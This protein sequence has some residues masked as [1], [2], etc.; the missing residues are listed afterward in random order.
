MCR[1][2]AAD[3]NICFDLPHKTQVQ[4]QQY[5]IRQKYKCSG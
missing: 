2:A 1:N 4:C 5:R 3:K